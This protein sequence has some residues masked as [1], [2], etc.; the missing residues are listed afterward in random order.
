MTAI[1]ISQIE[2][3]NPEGFQ[4][5]LQKSKKLA[6]LYGA[7]LMFRGKEPVALNGELNAHQFVVIA[8]FPNMEKLTAWHKS[9]EYR[10][11]VPLRDGASKQVMTAYDEVP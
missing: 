5:Y 1:M 9:A 6:G 8:E 4:D 2:V 7:K 10:A 3:I 11:L